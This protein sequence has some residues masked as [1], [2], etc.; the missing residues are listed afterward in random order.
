MSRK[1]VKREYELDRSFDYDD[2]YGFPNTRNNV[3]F[4]KR[5]AR[6]RLRKNGKKTCYNKLKEYLNNLL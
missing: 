4:V 6:K 3:G 2:A 1:S 5:R